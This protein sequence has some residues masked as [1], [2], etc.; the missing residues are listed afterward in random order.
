MYGELVPLGGGDSIPLLKPRLLVGRRD[1]CDIRLQFPNV[2]SQ[3][4][5]LELV[6]GYWQVRDLGSSNGTKVNGE[7][8]D[9]KWLLPEDEIS[10]A[11][12]KYT[13][14]YTPLST[15]PVPADDALPQL[16]LMEKAGLVKRRT[17][18]EPA[19]TRQKTANSKGAARVKPPTDEDLALQWLQEPDSDQSRPPG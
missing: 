4:C 5:E 1:R 3:H 16:S 9:T 17:G 15:E 14:K 19:E 2:S 10:I 8:I 7:R 11:S 18:N 13:A 6:N 12:H